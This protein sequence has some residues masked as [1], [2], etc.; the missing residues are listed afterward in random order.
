MRGDEHWNDWNSVAALV[1]VLEVEC[2]V[3]DLLD[4]GSSVF[5]GSDFELDNEDDV[6]C[7]EDS[8]N[9]LPHSW[10]IELEEDVPVGMLAEGRLQNSEFLLPCASL[11]FFQRKRIFCG[12]YSEESVMVFEEKFTDRRMVK[13]SNG[14]S[15][16]L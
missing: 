1:E 5:R 8:I 14:Q 7:D 9:A 12:E 2:I 16:S 6:L 13:G 11:L 4:C 10:D 15:V 3:D